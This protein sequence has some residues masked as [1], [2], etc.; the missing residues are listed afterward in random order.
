M[1]PLLLEEVNTFCGGLVGI[2]STGDP[3]RAGCNGRAHDL[4]NIVAALK[5]KLMFGIAPAEQLHQQQSNLQQA[6]S[7]EQ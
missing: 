7:K 2:Y 5:W 4:S 6:R 1:A 3:Q